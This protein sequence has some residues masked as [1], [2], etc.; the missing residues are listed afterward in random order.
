MTKTDLVNNL[1]VI[2]RSGTTQYLEAIKKGGD[3]NLI[4]QFG[5]GFYSYFLVA[6]RVT[7]IS[8]HPDDEQWAW[9]SK[10]GSTY[11]IY[12]DDGEERLTRGT[13]IILE[14]KKE[15][16]EY[17]KLS[18]I[19]ELIKRYSEF[20]NF[21]I[22][23]YKS[24]QVEKEVSVEDDEENAEVDDKEETGETKD[25]KVEGEENKDFDDLQL[26]D[27]ETPKDEEEGIK[28]DMAEGDGDDS[29]PVLDKDH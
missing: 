26:E 16:K 4:G 3:L 5:V 12:K 18:K 24:K 7:V 23:L 25:D 2:A 21:P 22:Y 10:A 28:V 11:R 29:K 17:L 20:I 19:E 1:G 15:Q 9:T 14:I 13:K 27:E 6:N 8:K